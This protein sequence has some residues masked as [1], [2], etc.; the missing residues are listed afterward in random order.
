MD[1]DKTVKIG[2]IG[3]GGI[4]KAHAKNLSLLGGN[5]VV[6]MCD[7]NPEHRSMAEA[8]GANFYSSVN[9]MVEAESEL[10]AVISCT[11]PVARL[12]V[13]KAAAALQARRGRAL[14]VFVEKPPA[15]SV[16][17][18]RSIVE[19]SQTQDL[20]VFV[21]FMYRHFPIVDRMKEL[22]G[23]RPI[24]LV[25]S[26]FYCPAA[27]I[28]QLPGWFYIKERSGGHIL[29]QAIHSIDL[30]R[31][32]A[33]DI[34]QVHTFGNNTL[35]PKSET[36]TIEE[37]SST[38]LRFASGASGS[39]LH[40]WTHSKM[41]VTLTL[42]GEDFQVTLGLDE[43][44]SGY[45]G[46]HQINETIPACPAEASHHYDEMKAFLQAVR[47]NDFN[48]MRSPYSDAAKSL[49]TVIAMNR[50]IESGAPEVVGTI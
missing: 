5:R 8:I 25:Q 39:H 24:H 7:M 4:W 29:D 12:E 28:W 41:A 22:V 9:A 16:Q 6:A 11:P 49:A 35:K 17:D 32:F 19:I 45:I 38:N 3:V 10:D 31:Y 23:E 20:P 15:F 14:P 1:N 46:D 48:I 36:F 13:V 2:A 26:S 30:I 50:S 18:A 27:T 42:I 44:L 37:S 43:T 21:G 33:G 47:S 40:S 34:A